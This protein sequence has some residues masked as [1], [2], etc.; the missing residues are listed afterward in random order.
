METDT[1]VQTR[2]SLADLLPATTGPELDRI[3]AELEGAVSQLE[4]SRDRL[5]PELPE[6]SLSG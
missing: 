1:F 5:S 4:A 2:W 6:G 3:L